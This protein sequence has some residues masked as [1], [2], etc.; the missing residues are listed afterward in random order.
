M[1]R[2]LQRLGIFQQWRAA[3]SIRRIAESMCREA[4]AAGYPRLEAETPYEYLKT[5]AQ[6]R[7]AN[8]G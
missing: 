5:L 8:S 6:T 7:P 1:D 4:A 2:L 3:A